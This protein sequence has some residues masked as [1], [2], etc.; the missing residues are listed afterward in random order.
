[1]NYLLL[2]HLI[3]VFKI[4]NVQENSCHLVGFHK[5]SFITQSPS[6]KKHPFFCMCMCVWGGG[7]SFV[8]F[9]EMLLII[10]N[11]TDT[12]TRSWQYQELRQPGAFS[13]AACCCACFLPIL[14]VKIKRNCSISRLQC[15]NVTAFWVA[16]HWTCLVLLSV[17]MFWEE[18][19][20]FVGVP[21]HLKAKPGHLTTFCLHV[22]LKSSPAPPPI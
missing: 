19:R 12:T 18:K 14:I 3:L 1:M 16:D 9:F 4:E 8:S 7:Y 13:S 6:C 5:S 22:C 17:N 21:A 15:C 20:Q 2:L 10:F 11:I